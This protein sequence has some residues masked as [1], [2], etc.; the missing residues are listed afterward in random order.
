[1][2]TVLAVLEDLLLPLLPQPATTSPSAI[3]NATIGVV[4]LMG[5]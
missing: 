1:V 5:A 3:S 4:R 2:G